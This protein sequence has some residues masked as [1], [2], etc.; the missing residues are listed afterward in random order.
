MIKFASVIALAFLATS[1]DYFKA[2]SKP[3][4]VAR[5]NDYYLYSDEIADL[6]PENVSKEDS[7]VIINNYINR[8][9]T[10]KILISAAEINL[11][12]EKQDQLNK[13]VNQ[14]KLDLYSKAYIEEVVKQS[15]DTVIAREEIEKYYSENKENF[16][17]NATLVRLRYIYLE[18]DNPKFDLIR[19]KFFDYKKSD[20]KFW[21]TN[22]LQFRKFALNDSVWVE[23][24]QIYSRLPFINP[25]NRDQ[26]IAPGK[27][28]Q[29][30]DGELSYLVKITNVLD[31]NQIAPL[32]FIEPTLREVI[33]NKRKLELI[34]K[35]E[36]D[37]TDD[38][39]KSKKYEIYK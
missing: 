31:K 2:S 19:Q 22:A 30:N 37:I 36:K 38:A 39:I 26:Y 21:E 3:D 10:N 5:V 6:I 13:L 20:R 15:V 9:A 17:T 14:Y 29:H 28:I 16:K 12:Q 7:A 18:K 23:M 27:S 1:C 24:S 34:K 25:E 11:N 33:L 8:W 4:A 35:F 32:Q